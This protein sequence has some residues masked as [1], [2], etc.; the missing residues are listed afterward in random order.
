MLEPAWAPG[1]RY[2]LPFDRHDWIVLRDGKE[3]RYVIDFYSGQPGAGKLV[4]MHID[5]RPGPRC[6]RATPLTCRSAGLGG[7]CG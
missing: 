7:E 3:V 5:A 2:A 1:R 4:G 6:H